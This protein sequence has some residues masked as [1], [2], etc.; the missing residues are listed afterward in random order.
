MLILSAP[1]VST[2]KITCRLHRRHLISTPS[3][4]TLASKLPQQQRSEVAGLEVAPVLSCCGDRDCIYAFFRSRAIQ[5]KVA[6]KAQ[7][8]SPW[9]T[10]VS[11]VG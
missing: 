9:A 2:G 11:T 5:T 1:F 3:A 8:I 7:S 10:R 4:T 6:M